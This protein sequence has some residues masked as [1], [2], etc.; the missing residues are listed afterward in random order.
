MEMMN[1]RPQTRLAFI[2]NLRWVVIAMVVLIHACVTYSGIGSWYYHEPAPLDMVSKLVFFFYESF[3]QAFFMG[4]LFLVAG[5]F[6]PAAYDRKGFG[7]FV[8][9]RLIRL[10]APTLIYMLV[11]D[12]VTRLIMERAQG[13]SI[14]FSML[15]AEYAA[16]LRNGAFL[17]RSGPLWF[18]L[19]LLVFSILYALFRAAVS[20]LIT[21]A[22][23][24]S[25]RTASPRAIHM[26]AAA[27]V[28]LLGLGSF[29]IRLWQPIGTS[30]LNMQL[31]FFPQYI[32]LFI[33]GLW[34][35]RSGFLRTVPKS[36]GAAWMRLAFAVG[37]PAW[38]LL[39]GLGGVL[40][41]NTAVIMGGP[42]WQA[43]GYALW[44]GFFCVAI[45][46]GLVT[47]FREKADTGT[48]LNGLLSRSSFGIYALHA[49]ILVA[50]TLAM[51]A[52]LMYPLAKA[53]LAAGIAF[54]ASLL[55]AVIVRRIPGLGRLF[56]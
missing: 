45:S 37:I 23:P 13:G 41:G 53:L 15:A 17:S 39:L 46:L 19:A 34:A 33:I 21:R 1:A 26:A 27:L 5:T 35:G 43:A 8:V 12:P 25:S 51:R 14:T 28:A 2:D 7:R 30:V 18:A 6:V 44:E 20:R 56:A 36:V 24:V 4:I 54:A 55:A 11:L 3:S 29:L 32:A 50:I 52:L 40:S 47:L 22:V 48:P 38:L 9:D 10:G 31:C 49:P 16:A 42:H